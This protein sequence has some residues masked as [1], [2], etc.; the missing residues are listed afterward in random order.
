M[1]PILFSLLL[2]ATAQ[3]AIADDLQSESTPID[4]MHALQGKWSV[5][6]EF[7]PS[8]DLPRFPNELGITTKENEFLIRG[9]QLIREGK[10]VAA[11]ANDLPLD[12]LKKEIGFSNAKLLILTLPSGKGLPCSYSFKDDDN[13]WIA[14]THKCF[15]NRGSGH[16][17]VLKRVK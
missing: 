2:L 1:K 9:N 16:I 3:T 4:D 14:H 11:I 7:N 12:G 15:C 6:G 13:L 17:A 5:V 8:A 10:A